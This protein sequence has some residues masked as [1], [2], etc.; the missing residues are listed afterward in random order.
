MLFI[1]FGQSIIR[2]WVGSALVAEAGFLLVAAA[3]SF[4]GLLVGLVGFA[5]NA[6]DIV[7]P[8]A[9]LGLVMA[10]VSLPLTIYLANLVGNF[11]PVLASLVTHASIVAVPFILLLRRALVPTPSDVTAP[12]KVRSE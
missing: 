2:L 8:Q 5:L 11:G 1:V 12:G 9:V 7:M 3:W 4:Y 10:A 6:A